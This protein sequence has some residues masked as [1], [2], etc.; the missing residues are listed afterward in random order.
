MKPFRIKI[1][2]ERRKAWIGRLFVLPWVLGFL[3][4]FLVPFVQSFYFTFCS[5]EINE[6][7][8]KAT[9]GGFEGFKWLDNYKAI[10]LENPKFLPALI[11][12]VKSIIYEVPVIL[13]F[14]IF[15][16]I[17]L[18]QKFRGRFLAR[19]VFFLPVIVTSGII[20]QII[21][22]DVFASA[23][24]SG[25]FA[26]GFVFKTSG[27]KDMMI[28][29]GVDYRIIGYVTTL[30]NSIFDLLWKSG[31]QILLFLAGL[32]TVPSNYYEASD[33]EG[34]TAWESFWKIT[35]PLLSPIIVLNIVY[36]IIDNFTFYSNG[37]MT[38]INNTTFKD[39]NYTYGTAMAFTYF[40]IVFAIVMLINRL[41]SKKA[42]Y[43]VH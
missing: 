17:I 5:L 32:Q 36:T 6:V 2:Y 27:M 43:A 31:I 11:G 10:F 15:I 28:Q 25:N 3:L 26:S 21:K 22:N 8:Y 24:M 18:N 1:P 16:A 30:L 20:I 23:I 4:F 37:M 7:G 40:V 12:S 38:L 34:A 29:M 9:F 33:I 39:L 19:A 14:S 42:F 35:F 13:A 41:V